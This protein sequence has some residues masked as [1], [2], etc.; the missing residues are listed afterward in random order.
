[1]YEL[2]AN[3]ILQINSLN[4]SCIWCVSLHWRAENTH[5]QQHNLHP[6]NRKEFCYWQHEMVH[7]HTQNGV[8]VFGSFLS[9]E[10]Y[11]RNELF[12]GGSCHRATSTYKN[13]VCVS[14][15]CRL[16]KNESNNRTKTCPAWTEHFEF[17]HIE[18]VRM[19]ENARTSHNIPKHVWCG[20]RTIFIDYISKNALMNSGCYSYSTQHYIVRLYQ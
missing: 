7:T 16:K 18:G 4:L 11:C 6:I 20:I 10:N 15:H 5:A 9:K 17:R 2:H 12:A 19:C 8:F 3:F 1:M 13:Y 14:F